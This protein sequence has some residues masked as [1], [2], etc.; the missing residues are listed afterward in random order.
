MEDRFKKTV[1]M[2]KNYRKLQSKLSMWNL[3]K[4]KMKYKFDG[5]NAIGYEERSSPTH[6]FNSNVENEVINRSF[7]FEVI[8]KNIIYYENQIKEIEIALDMLTERER[9]IIEKK[10]FDKIKNIDIALDLDLTEEYVCDLKR[11]IVNKLSDIL[12]LT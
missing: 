8:E 4:E 2:L 7:D 9:F 11:G 5:V 3:Q 10:Y 1:T 12:F 6:K